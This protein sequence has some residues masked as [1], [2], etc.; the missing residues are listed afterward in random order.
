M[1]SFVQLSKLS[2]KPIGKFV[3][4]TILPSATHLYATCTK[5][6]KTALLRELLK[7]REIVHYEEI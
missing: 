6:L 2:N 1:E 4:S 3:L 7:R 5:E